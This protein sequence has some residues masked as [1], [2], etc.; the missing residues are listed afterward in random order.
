[1]N[2][3]EFINKLSTLAISVPRLIE[4][5]YSSEYAEAL[6]KAFYPT[7]TTKKS[8]SADSIFQLIEEYDIECIGLISRIKFNKEVTETGNHFL[9]G[10][11]GEDLIAIDKKNNEVVILAY[12][13][14][15]L[16][17][18]YCSQTTDKFLEAFL[19][20]GIGSLGM[21]FEKEEDQWAYNKSKAKEASIAAGGI[22]YLE[23]WMN[24]YPADNNKSDEL[25]AQGFLN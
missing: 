5:G 20:H 23:F 19:I 15:D 14:I 17:C 7:K 13:D 3:V 12:W 22:R 4:T 6:Y 1:M 16:V 10:W 8:L 21:K 2:A 9:I 11:M 18:Y 25:N 24:L